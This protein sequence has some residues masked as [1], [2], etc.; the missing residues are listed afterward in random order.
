MKELNPENNENLKVVPQ[1]LTAR[2]EDF[3]WAALA[4]QDL[5]YD[6]VNYNLG[7]PAGTVVARGKGSGFLRNLAGLERFLDEIFAPS[8]S[9]RIS[10]KVRLGWANEEEFDDISNLLKN[11]PASFVIIHPRLKTDQYRGEVRESVFARYYRRFNSPVAFNGDVVK[12]EDIGRIETAYPSL[13]MIM[14]GRGLTADPALF[15]KARGGKPASKEEIKEFSGI[16]Y[17]GYTKAFESRRN[18]L[19][20]MKEHWFYLLNLFEEDARLQKKLFKAKTDADFEQAVAD[21]FS[22]LEILPKA[23]FGWKKPA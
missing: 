2:S 3:N 14:V 6:E 10:I 13:S 16:L 20:R 8:R 21:V 23:R 12:E 15:R 17:D 5:G 18:A 19:M 4:L 1:L 7:C 9:I 22:S 11:Y